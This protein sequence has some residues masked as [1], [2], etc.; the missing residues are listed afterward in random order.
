MLYISKPYSS[1][2]P[3]L[4]ELNAVMLLLIHVHETQ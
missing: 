2:S 1:F 4:N 3:L